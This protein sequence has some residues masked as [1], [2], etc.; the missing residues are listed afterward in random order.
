MVVSYT[1][2][3]LWLYDLVLHP[4]PDLRLR[5]SM[6]DPAVKPGGYRKYGAA[7]W[8]PD[9]SAVLLPY[10]VAEPDD[11]EL[12]ESQVPLELQSCN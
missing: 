3:R 2:T 5:A 6:H 11:D 12:D 4:E 1:N 8:M 10:T 9:G 7:E